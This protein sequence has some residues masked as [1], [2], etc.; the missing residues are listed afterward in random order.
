MNPGPDF[1]S[2]PGFPGDP[3]FPGQPGFPGDLGQPFAGQPFAGQPFAGQMGFPRQFGFPGGMWRQGYAGGGSMRAFRRV[4]FVMA[5]FLILIVIAAFVAF[6][7][8]QSS[9]SPS[10]SCVGGPVT[11]S[12][13]QS[14]GNGNY[15]FNCADGGSTI[16]HLGN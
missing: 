6:G 2:Q 1:P 11:G 10:G 3:A 14:M 16:I 4:A 7:R 9:S 5:A 8:L 15:K 13:G 12:T